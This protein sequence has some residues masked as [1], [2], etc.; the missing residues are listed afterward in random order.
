MPKK[1]KVVLKGFYRRH[2]LNRPG[3]H[4][5]AHVIASTDTI[6]EDTRYNHDA[7]FDIAD[8]S[9]TINLYFD[10]DDEKCRKN[11]M[12]KLDTLIKDLSDFRDALAK[13]CELSDMI[14]ENLKKYN[15][16]KSN[17]G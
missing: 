6:Y 7:S 1:S 8:C 12:H 14:D 17:D 2:F 16:K 3:M 9:R 4:S 13:Q 5:H 15:E 10:M 11:S